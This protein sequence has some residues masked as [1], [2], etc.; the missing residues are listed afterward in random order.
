MEETCQHSPSRSRGA[1][2]GAFGDSGREADSNTG[3]APGSHPLRS[4]ASR[5]FDL[6]LRILLLSH[7]VCVPPV[8][9]EGLGAAESELRVLSLRSSFL[10]RKPDDLLHPSL[11]AALLGGV[12]RLTS[13]D[14][15]VCRAGAGAGSLMGPCQ[16][17][18][19]LPRAG[20]RSP[21]T[22]EGPTL[23]N[24]HLTEQC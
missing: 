21:L 6:S 22:A 10:P 19:Q 13:G 15:M 16:G 18:T 24:G 8:Q 7:R 23:G 1:F 11:S 14:C 2:G 4:L 12:A 17:Q 5:C 9:P 20:L 3:R